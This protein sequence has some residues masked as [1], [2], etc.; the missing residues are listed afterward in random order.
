MNCEDTLDVSVPVRFENVAGVP[1]ASGRT[2]QEGVV[3]PFKNYPSKNYQIRGPNARS[4]REQDYIPL[5]HAQRF[6]LLAQSME[7]A[8]PRCD[9]APEYNNE[10]PF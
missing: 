7:D 9:G 8:H 4:L 1:L 3:E 2:P 6:G 10:W 5:L